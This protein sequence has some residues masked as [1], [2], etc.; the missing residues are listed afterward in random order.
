MSWRKG[1]KGRGNIFTSTPVEG[2]EGQRLE[3]MEDILE[4]DKGAESTLA[5]APGMDR[6]GR[7]RRWLGRLGGRLG[8]RLLE[9]VAKILAA[10]V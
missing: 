7:A 6:R 10:V 8:G 3:D 4:E 1:S 9:V 2:E 5:R